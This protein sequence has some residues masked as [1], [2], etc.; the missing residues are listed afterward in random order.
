ML[1][2]DF[3]ERM[4]PAPLFGNHTLDEIRGYLNADSLQYLSVEGLLRATG[5]EFDKVC[6]A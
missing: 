4:V 3:D 5:G 2:V 1:S 6:T